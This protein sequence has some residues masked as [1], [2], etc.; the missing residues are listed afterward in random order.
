MK[1]QIFNKDGTP[2]GHP[3]ILFDHF[4]KTGVRATLKR[5]EEV[6]NPEQNPEQNSDSEDSY[7]TTALL[8]KASVYFRCI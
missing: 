8:S 3:F 5:P 7:L 2:I 1:N 6:Q 4:L